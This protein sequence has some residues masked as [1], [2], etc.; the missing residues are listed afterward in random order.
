M[1]CPERSAPQIGLL[2]QRKVLK[3]RQVASQN[4]ATT[5]ERERERESLVLGAYEGVNI[6]RPVAGKPEVSVQ[7]VLKMNP[8]ESDHISEVLAGFT[9]PRQIVVN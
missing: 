5:R 9:K 2:G 4:M 8:H 3:T 1:M 7:D 6:A